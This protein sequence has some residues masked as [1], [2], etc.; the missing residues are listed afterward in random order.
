LGANTPSVK[1]HVQC[2]I[3]GRMSA[4]GRSVTHGDAGDDDV[5]YN[6]G[7]QPRPLLGRKPVGCG[8]IAASRFAAAVPTVR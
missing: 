1:V 4:A 8:S 7:P 6:D 3:V 5:D 2:G